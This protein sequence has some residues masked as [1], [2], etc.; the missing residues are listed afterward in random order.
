MTRFRIL[1]FAAIIFIPS[2]VNAQTFSFD[3]VAI[4]EESYQNSLTASRISGSLPSD[5]FE[6]DGE[7]ASAPLAEV[8]SGTHIANSLVLCGLATLILVGSGITVACMRQKKPRRPAA[9]VM[10]TTIS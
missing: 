3:T 4:Q 1:V 10:V 5:I 7:S 8:E 6:L 2:N 9:P